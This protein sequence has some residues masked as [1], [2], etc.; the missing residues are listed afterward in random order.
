VA[1]VHE[2]EV[3]IFLRMWVFRFPAVSVASESG[4]S[5]VLRCGW[6]ALCIG[7]LVGNV[8][9]ELGTGGAYSTL[10]TKSM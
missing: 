3:A 4:W 1:M 8:F 2:S 9:C 7:G 5:C 6:W 10:G